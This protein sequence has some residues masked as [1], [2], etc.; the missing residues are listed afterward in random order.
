MFSKSNFTYLA[1]TT[2]IVLW[3][4]TAFK[5]PVAT[6]PFYY[7]S[8]ALKNQARPKEE[9]NFKS[10]DSF[11][12][13]RTEIKQAID[14]DITVMGKLISEWDIEAE[15]LEYKGYDNV[16]RLDRQDFIRSQIMT[17][18][19]CK[20]DPSE[21]EI[22]RFQQR[23]RV[24]IDNTGHPLDL[25][26]PYHKFLPQTYLSAGIL[27]AL[28]DPSQIVAL[29][30]G[31][32]NQTSIYPEKTT[33]QIDTDI[34][35]FHCERISLTAPDIAIVAQY[36]SHPSTLQ[37]LSSQGIEMF[38]MGNI[39]DIKDVKKS[40]S[41][42][43]QICN[44]PL[45]SELMNIFIEAALNAIDN[46]RLTIEDS[47]DLASVLIVNHHTQYSLP[48]TKTLTFSLMKR[49]GIPV[50]STL[51]NGSIDDHAW[52]VPLQEEKIIG[53][54]PKHLLIITLPNES[55]LD[56]FYQTELFDHIDASKNRNVTILDEQ[57]QQSPSQY[58]VLAY[59]D[60]NQAL[61]NLDEHSH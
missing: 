3:W 25:S 57:V 37:A 5:N 18:T 4:L 38:C 53:M 21:I 33:S 46:K 10:I 60:I 51:F 16:K 27:M 47:I 39:C 1:S 30:K 13:S 22:I 7:N 58:I 52:S 32:R 2:I 11:S 20:A 59:Y 24:V 17:K 50:N 54:N 56:Y 55:I 35:S 14:G 19:L 6:E 23:Q 29:P 8:E 45:K 43:G 42:L 44:R 40:I 12:L 34:D 48:G 41:D 31:L 26:L 36:Y 15:I 28:I 49:M 9:L 61:F